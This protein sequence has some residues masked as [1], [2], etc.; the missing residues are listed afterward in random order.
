MIRL[1]YMAMYL[2]KFTNNRIQFARAV[3]NVPR[4]VDIYRKSKPR[5]KLLQIRKGPESNPVTII[6]RRASGGITK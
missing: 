4:K 1:G 5:R 6:A 2:L 3:F